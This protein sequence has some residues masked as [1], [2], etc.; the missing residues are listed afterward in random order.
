MGENRLKIKIFKNIKDQDKNNVD[1]KY[2]G[3]ILII[4][5]LIQVIL[6]NNIEHVVAVDDENPGIRTGQKMCIIQ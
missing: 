5:L 1:F 2:F 3:L 6:E 4:G